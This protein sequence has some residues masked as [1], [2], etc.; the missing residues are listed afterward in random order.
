[1]LTRN[2][3]TAFLAL[4]ILYWVA[5]LLIKGTPVTVELLL[6]FGTV[7]TCVSL[8]L[9]A[10]DRWLWKLSLFRGW[11]IKRPV[12]GG[13]WRAE[14]RSDWI[15]TETGKTLPPIPCYM[16]VRQ[17]ASALTFRLITR[18]SRSETVSAGIEDCADGTYEVNCAYRNRPRAEFRHRSEVHYGAFL[19]TA[20]GLRPAHLEGDYW[21]DRKTIGTLSLIERKAGTCIGFEECERLFVSAP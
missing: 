7:V 20:E 1:M 14:I 18:E 12:L 4:S 5:L 9:L 16:V 3:I 2:Q 11:L 6:P 10:F 21:T 13:V 15:S 8:S 17:T 19:L